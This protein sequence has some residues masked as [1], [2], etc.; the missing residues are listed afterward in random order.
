MRVLNPYINRLSLK[1]KC[2]ASYDFNNLKYLSADSQGKKDD[3]LSHN[4]SANNDLSIEFSL[5]KVGEKALFTRGANYM[6]TPAH[7][8]FNFQNNAWSMSSWLLVS[9]PSSS[10]SMQTMAGIISKR[11]NNLNGINNEF[12]MYLIAP[13]YTHGGGDSRLVVRKSN[14]TGDGGVAITTVD[15]WD[16]LF[17]R[18]T[19]HHIV[20]TCEGGSDIYGKIYLDGQEV[21]CTYA[22]TGSAYAGMPITSTPI[23][24]NMPV[25]NTTAQY[26]LYGSSD[27]VSFWNRSLSSSEVAL[28]FNGGAGLSFNN[29]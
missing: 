6:Y 11:L 13:T 25:Y 2:I 12:D 1:H 16:E 27:Q 17:A 3:V 5:G 19:W 14:T 9:A 29:W 28:L 24:Y 21:S 22:S 7:G 23:R 18:S 8:D 10:L 15:G 20:Y 4:L 26:R